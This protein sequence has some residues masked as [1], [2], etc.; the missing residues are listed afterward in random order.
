MC[1]PEIR[2]AHSLLFCQKKRHRR[3]HETRSTDYLAFRNLGDAVGAAK[4]HRSQVVDWLAI[5][6][7]AAAEKAAD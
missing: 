4:A 1:L 7:F 2:Q 6:R 3:T 5:R